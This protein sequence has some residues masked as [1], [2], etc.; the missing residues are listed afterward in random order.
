M[1]TMKEI[2]Q[3]IEASGGMTPSR[4]LRGFTGGKVGPID[5]GEFIGGNY[6]SALNLN[7]TV[8]SS[9]AVTVAGSP[10]ALNMDEPEFTMS[11]L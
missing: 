5:G 8:R 6:A 1:Q 11:G 7:S 9:I 10:A 4:R 2:F 3:E